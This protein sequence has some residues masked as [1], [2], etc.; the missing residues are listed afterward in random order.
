MDYDDQTSDFMNSTNS[1][2]PLPPT[3]QLPPLPP[4][5]GVPTTPSSYLPVEELTCDFIHTSMVTKT[6]VMINFINHNCPDSATVIGGIRLRSD[7]IARIPA[8]IARH[9]T[10]IKTQ[11]AH[12]LQKHLNRCQSALGITETITVDDFSLSFMLA[13]VSDI[14]KSLHPTNRNE[15][16]LHFCL[17]P[18]LCQLTP[19]GITQEGDV[20][21]CYV[22]NAYI[23][24]MDAARR[25]NA[26]L[27]RKH[28][29]DEK[30]EQAAAQAAKAKSA[31]TSPAPP[32]KVKFQMKRS[33]SS[34]QVNT[35]EG[36]LKDIKDTVRQLAKE[37]KQLNLP[38]PK[39]PELPS[40]PLVWPPVDEA[41]ALPEEL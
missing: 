29:E 38:T 36:D 31:P 23:H 12:F 5:H 41:P 17:F 28:E 27:K 2:P 6:G 35:N 30:K 9:F 3:P 7:E 18:K 39:Y 20:I 26:V 21:D 37:V 16:P 4:P 15:G 34:S 40:A 19:I 8:I 11:A 32:K 22:I 24:L 13:S 10:S 14:G 25:K 33:T 1:R